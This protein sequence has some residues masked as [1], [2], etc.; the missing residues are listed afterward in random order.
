[1]AVPKMLNDVRR[2]ANFPVPDG[3]LVI[4]AGAFKPYTL[5]S[6]FPDCFDFSSKS[7]VPFIVCFFRVASWVFLTTTHSWFGNR[8]LLRVGVI[9]LGKALPVIDIAQPQHSL[10]GRAQNRQ[11]LVSCSPKAVCRK[12]GG[13]G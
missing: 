9:L 6:I 2:E 12:Y 3:K 8:T 10:Q 4:I 1:M 7:H 5:L 11:K 13:R